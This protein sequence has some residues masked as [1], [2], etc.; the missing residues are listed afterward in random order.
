MSAGQIQSFFQSKV[1]VCQA[2]YTCLKD[3]YDTSR[4]T[5]ADAMCRAYPGGVRERASTIVYKVAQACGINPQVLIVTLQKEQGLVTHTWPSEWRYTI[6]MGQGC[7][8]TA[9]CDTRYYGFFNQVYGAAWQMKRYANP[10]GTSN[11][12]NWYAPRNTWNVLFHPN[13][14]CGTSPVSIQNQATANLYYYTPYQP[15]GAALRAGYGQGDGCSSYGNRNFYN[16]FTDWFG[17]TQKPANACSTPAGANAAKRTYV[18]TAPLNARIAPST[19]CET[20][21][22]TLA[23]GTVVQAVAGSGEWLKVHV[24]TSDR[25]VNR[26]YLR[27]A[28]AAESA[29]ALPGGVQSAKYAY[30]VGQPVVAR[31]VPNGGC[32]AGQAPVATGTI[33]QAIA[34]NA[35]RTWIKVHAGDSDRWI[36]RSTVRRATPVETPCAIP[37]GVGAAIRAY[38]IKPEGTAGR[39]AP[40]AACGMGATRLSGGLIVQAEQV[41][42]DRTFI[43]VS[44]GRGHLW[45]A[46]ADVT[47]FDGADACATAPATRVAT[48]AYVVLDGGTTARRQ[49]TTSCSTGAVDLAAGTLLAPAAGTVAGDWLRVTSASG[50]RWVPRVSVRTATQDD[51]CRQPTDAAAAKRQYV[52]SASGTTARVGPHPSCTAG[53]AKVP[54]GTVAVAVAVTADGSWL[55]LKLGVGDRWVLRR[56]VTRAP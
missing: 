20:R 16:Y 10:P 40:S 39:A 11:F 34:V 54:G 24:E 15:N 27:Y 49:P 12:F 33:L 4:T 6:A 30:V 21:K 1:P 29:C 46:R 31:I 23:A 36:M 44:T 9:A 8:D 22:M 17:S 48:R 32:G 37:G 28:T 52:V 13:R 5:T 2:G 42:A 41:S 19:S 14:A 18:V 43:K 25:W 55:K 56:D 7:P 53:S 3:K 51:V 50:E 47:R 45:V 35:D 38:L 26:A